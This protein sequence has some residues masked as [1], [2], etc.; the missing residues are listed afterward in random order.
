MNGLYKN[1]GQTQIAMDIDIQVTAQQ[2]D[3]NDYT[4]GAEV[5]YTKVYGS[6]NT[7]GNEALAFTPPNER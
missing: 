6:A 5:N 7:T 2:I 4:I 3:N 1:G